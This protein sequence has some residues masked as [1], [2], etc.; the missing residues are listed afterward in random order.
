MTA[1]TAILAGATG[2]VGSLCLKQLLDDPTYSQVVAVTRRPVPEAHPKFVQKIVDFDQL[3]QLAPIAADDAFCALGTTIKKAGSQ[4]SFRKV[5]V[6]YSKAFAGFALA[7]GSRQLALVSSVG[8]NPRSGNFYVRTKG[9]LE[10]AVSAMAFQSIHI[11]Q[12][13]FLMGLR[14][15]Q[16]P[17]EGIGLALARAFQFVLVGGLR[18]YRPISAS[19]VAAAMIAAV[20]CAEPGRH[21]YLFDDIEALAD[22][23]LAVPKS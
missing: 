15:E 10:E 18:K 19:A 12:P 7:G 1:R 17:G 8:A 9:E 16:R 13:S 21:I 11:F 14:A 2:L 6:G 4:D 3:N 20:K 22:R 23:R 5:D